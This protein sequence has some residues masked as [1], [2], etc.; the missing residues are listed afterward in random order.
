MTNITDTQFPL[1]WAEALNTSDRDVFISEW[2]TSSLFLAPD[3]DGDIPAELIEWLGQ[4]WDVAHMSLSEIRATTGLSQ[5]KMADRFCIPRRTVQNWE[6]R[7][8]CPDYTRLMMA[9][10]LG[11]IKR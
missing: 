11:L 10:I 3:D 6:Q 2:A 5:N 1:L 8:T 4:L 9:D 7:G